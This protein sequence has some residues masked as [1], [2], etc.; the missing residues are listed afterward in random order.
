MQLAKTASD[1]KEINTYLSYSRI[2]YGE[3]QVRQ[4]LTEL[5]QVALQE[6]AA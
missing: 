6:D 1:R 3:K 4:H 5:E 2:E